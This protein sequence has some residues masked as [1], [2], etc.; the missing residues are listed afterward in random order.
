MR[1]DDPDTPS[2]NAVKITERVEEL[3]RRLRERLVKGAAAAGQDITLY[4]DAVLFLLFHRYH[5]HF[6]EVIHRAL[7]QK[8]GQGR[9]GFYGEFLNDW[10]QYLNVPGIS[11]AKEHETPHLFACFFQLCRSVHHIFEAIIGSSMVAARLRN[12]SSRMIC[13]VIAARCTT[14]W[15]TSPRSSAG[16]RARAKNLWPGL[17][18]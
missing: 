18:D 14:A 16:P 4:E 6:Y 3:V 12:R 1:V 15:M 11:L 9:C 8:R 7:A 5:N 13:G 17:L 10:K 2:V